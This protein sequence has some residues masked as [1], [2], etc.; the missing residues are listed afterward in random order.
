MAKGGNG[1]GKGDRLNQWGESK[2]ES[3]LRAKYDLKAISHF[4][5]VREETG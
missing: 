5:P 2:D 1:H 3:A 4:H